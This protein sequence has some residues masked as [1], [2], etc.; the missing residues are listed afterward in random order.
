MPRGV[1]AA[2]ARLKLSPAIFFVEAA[3]ATLDA[4]KREVTLPATGPTGALV[5]DV[6]L[7]AENG[8]GGGSTLTVTLTPPNSHTRRST[9]SGRRKSS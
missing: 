6:R 9:T 5:H 2:V 4:D 1:R 3:N 8:V 7:L